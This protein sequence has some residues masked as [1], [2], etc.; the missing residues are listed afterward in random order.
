[1]RFAARAAVLAWT[2]TT[3]SP[4][5]LAANAT[6]PYG[7]VNHR[8]DAGN[9]TGD[10]EVERLNENQLGAYAPEQAQPG[11]DYGYS[12]GSRPPY[13]GGYGLPQGGYPSAYVGQ[14]SYGYA[15]GYPYPPAYAYPPAYRYPPAY[16]APYGYPAPSGYAAPNGYQ[17][18]Y[19][20]P[21]PGYGPAPGYA[22]AP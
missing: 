11:Y 3:F 8:N 1:M 20:Y 15:P 17:A 5:C 12:Q 22:Y 14:P 21:P 9:D 2:A 6:N 13:A 7:N 18:P 10:S 4:A 16:P 19:G